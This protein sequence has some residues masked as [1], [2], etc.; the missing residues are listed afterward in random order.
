MAHL[1]L[2]GYKENDF[3]PH[4]L[5]HHCLL[6]KIHLKQTNRNLTGK[7]SHTTK[8]ESDFKVIVQNSNAWDSAGG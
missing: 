8:H 3:A 1:F 2:L 7:A 6:S 4:A 5:N